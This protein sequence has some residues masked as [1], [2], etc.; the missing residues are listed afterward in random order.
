MFTPEQ[1]QNRVFGARGFLERYQ[2][3]WEE[4]LDSTVTGLRNTITP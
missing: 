3:E 4:S 2:N 1:K